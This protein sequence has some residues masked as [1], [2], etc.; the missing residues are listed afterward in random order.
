M[1]LAFVRGCLAACFFSRIEPI[2]DTD[3]QV[4][5]FP[6]SA[7]I[8]P[9]YSNFYFWHTQRCHSHHAESDSAVGVTTQSQ[10]DHASQMNSDKSFPPWSQNRKLCRSQVALKGTIRQNTCMSRPNHHGCK[11]LKYKKGGS[12]RLNFDSIVSLRIVITF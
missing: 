8:S 9:T 10:E 12:L 6:N 5:Q 1:L 4:T 11:D 7:S 3:K 2:W